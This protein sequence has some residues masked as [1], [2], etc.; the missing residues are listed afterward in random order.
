M[1]IHEGS[2]AWIAATGSDAAASVRSP[3]DSSP[4]SEIRRTSGMPAPAEAAATIRRP[5]TARG[6]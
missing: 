5:E 4:P 3:V 2:M 1:A 6:W